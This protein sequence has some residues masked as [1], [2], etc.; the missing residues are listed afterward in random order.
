ML[1]VIKCTETVVFLIDFY[2]I[3]Q[4]VTRS[5]EQGYIPIVLLVGG[6]L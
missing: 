4:A 2:R 6:C 3:W 5:E 1:L